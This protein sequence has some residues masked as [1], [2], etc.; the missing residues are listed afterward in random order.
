MV[1]VVWMM[2]GLEGPRLR[3]GTQESFLASDEDK[4]ID[5]KIRNQTTVLLGCIVECQLSCLAELNMYAG[6]PGPWSAYMMGKIVLN[7]QMRSSP[8]ET[9]CFL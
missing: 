9:G 2:G 4:M 8:W 3:A 1:V 7:V 5:E 6:M